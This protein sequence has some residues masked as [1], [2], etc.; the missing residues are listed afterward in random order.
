MSRHTCIICG[1]KRDEQYMKALYRSTNTGY[2]WICDGPRY[3][4]PSMWDGERSCIDIYNSRKPVVEISGSKDN[5]DPKCPC[6][7]NTDS[8]ISEMS[9]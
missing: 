4:A 3:K 7:R 5:S 1:K 8:L 2:V 6:S 9:E